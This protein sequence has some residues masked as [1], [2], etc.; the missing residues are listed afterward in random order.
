MARFGIR[1]NK[2]SGGWTTPEL[3]KL[4]RQIGRNHALAEE[5]W[6][7]GIFEARVLATLVDEPAQVS[8]RQMDRWAKDFDNWAVCDGACINLFRYTKFAHA[9]CLVWST[10]RK[11]FVKRA[12]FALMAGLAVAD[13]AAGDEAFLKFLPV[14]K[15]AAGDER[16]FVKKAVNWALR[17]IGKRNRRLHRA[18]LAAARE[19]H[20]LDSRAARW[21]SSDA[22]REL[23]SP[24]LEVG[25][26]RAQAR[27][28]LKNYRGPSP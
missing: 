11:E 20:S 4:A 15:S 21:I 9:K 12:A 19:I 6:A 8:S 5:L 22:L 24:A 13:K 28:Y 1:A 27:R 16:N 23:R 26:R 18:A 7:S 25:T 14:I 2:V 17:Q 3:K 10:R